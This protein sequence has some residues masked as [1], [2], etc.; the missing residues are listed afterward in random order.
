MCIQE[1][2]NAS[3]TKETINK[4]VQGKLKKKPRYQNNWKK[5]HQ[6]L[7]YMCIL[8]L[9][10]QFKMCTLFMCVYDNFKNHIC[11]LIRK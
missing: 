1:S 6:T 2:V 4:M 10:W 7:I 5:T 3:Q 11:I 9:L 8:R